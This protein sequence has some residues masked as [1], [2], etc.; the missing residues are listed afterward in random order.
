MSVALKE[1]SDFLRLLDYKILFKEQE[2]KINWALAGEMVWHKCER[3]LNS[4]GSNYP[5]FHFL[6]Y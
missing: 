2:F 3:G 4:C 1:I 6:F 5:C